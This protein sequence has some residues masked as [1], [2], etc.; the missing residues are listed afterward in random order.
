MEKFSS[1][2]GNILDRGLWRVGNGSKW[3]KDKARNELHCHANIS[4]S[5]KTLPKGT[6][7]SIGM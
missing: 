2:I 7:P 4:V 6:G 5:G 1:F 3:R